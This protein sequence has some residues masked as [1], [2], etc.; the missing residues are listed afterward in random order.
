MQKV[1]RSLVVISVLIFGLAC[2]SSAA[3][4]EE[5][6]ALA[7]KAAAFMKA[8]GK[9]KAVAEFNNPQGQFV[10]GD[11]YVFAQDFNGLMLANGGNPK[12]SGQNHLEL[13]DPTGKNFVKEMI[14]IAK[15]KGG[16]W[17]NYSWTN[18]ATKK[19]APKKTWV[20][21]VEGTDIYVG[22]GIFQ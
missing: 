6:K 10:K 20:Q 1:L 7:E 12:L 21:R 17:V 9:E 14:E 11:L 22:C 19:V 8:N 15:T 13:K 5:A 3:T 18:P 2:V 16:G 4:L